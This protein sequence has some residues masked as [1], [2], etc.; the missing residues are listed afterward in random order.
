M[1]D[2]TEWAEG[3]QHALKTLKVGLALGQVY[4]AAAAEDRRTFCTRLD[5]EH[6]SRRMKRGE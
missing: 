2:T 1:K 4:S 3:G 6:R 5:R